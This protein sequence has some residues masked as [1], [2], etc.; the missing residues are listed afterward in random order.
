MNSAD[1]HLPSDLDLKVREVQIQLAYK[2][3]FNTAFVNPIT[4]G[5]V[6]VALWSQVPAIRLVLW[7][8][9]M[10]LAQLVRLPLVAAYKR[11]APTGTDILRW[12]H[13]QTAATVL[14]AL[15]RYSILKKKRW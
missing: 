5:M 10:V 11:Q 2:Q 3:T 6:V 8:G 4:A 9:I 14:T 12:N 1:T 15:I 13:Y 7:F